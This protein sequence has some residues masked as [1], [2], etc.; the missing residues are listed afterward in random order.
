M[1][2]VTCSFDPEEPVQSGR[3]STIRGDAYIYCNGSPDVSMTYVRLWRYD[4]ARRAYYLHAEST[5]SSTASGYRLQQVFGSCGGN[6]LY[7][8]HV[9]VYNESFHGTWGT[10]EANSFSRAFYC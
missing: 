1:H 9:Q 5:S 3:N 4:R 8:F 2:N 6:I 7:D 10:S